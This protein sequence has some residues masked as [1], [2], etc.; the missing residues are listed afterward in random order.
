M[1]KVLFAVPTL[2]AL[3]VQHD[4][5]TLINHWSDNNFEVKLLL[6]SRTGDFADQFPS[7]IDSIEVDDFILNIPKLRVL[8]R[9]TYG[10]FRAIASYNPDVIISFVPF[11]N[12]SCFLAKKLFGLKFSLVVSEHA[13]VSAAMNDV[14]NMDN[15]FMK[16]YRK[17]FRYVY[18][19]T[20]VDVV[21][22]I[23]IES[24]DD[25]LKEHKIDQSKTR[26]IHNP[27]PINEIILK[28]KEE[29]TF[30]NNFCN[31]N[32]F[33]IINSGRI[34]VQKRQD[35]LI[36]SFAVVNAKFPETRLVILGKGDS[37][38]LFMLAK[39]LGVE[40]FIFFAGFQ[41]NPW[42]WVSKAQLF[43][44]TSCWEGL[45]CVISETM[46]LGVPIVSTDCPSGPK[47]MLMDGELGIL[48]KTD[49]VEDI[50]NKI[51]QAIENFSISMNKAQKAK[52]F[53]YR[54]DPNSVTK[55]YEEL[56]NSLTY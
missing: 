9:M 33:I 15:F 18:N 43:V 54:Y 14:Q 44:L 46:A 27:I 48:A 11:S 25:L 23:S 3:G 8:E 28:G 29:V 52:D 21:K 34:T 12:Y 20:L 17:T 47:E 41:R 10:Y 22:C 49:D 24:M 35:L 40:N 36:K 55:Q 56:V 39:E 4:I 26:L 6:N 45:P 7:S 13:H 50:T 32:S 19:N 30:P 2:D 16:I 53:L 37:N 51:I 5:L 31:E 1:K 38:E 42:K